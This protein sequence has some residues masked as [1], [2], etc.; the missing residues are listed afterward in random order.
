MVGGLYVLGDD[1]PSDWVKEPW[2]RRLEPVSVTLLMRVRV[3]PGSTSQRVLIAF[4]SAALDFRHDAGCAFRT[5]A[6]KRAKGRVLN[7]IRAASRKKQ[8]AD[9]VRLEANRFRES[10]AQQGAFMAMTNSGTVVVPNRVIHDPHDFRGDPLRQV[11][12]ADGEA[13][14][15][16]KLTPRE[17]AAL[18]VLLSGQRQTNADKKALQRARKKL[19]RDRHLS[20]TDGG[21][22]RD[23]DQEG[24]REKL[25]A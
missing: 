8:H 4:H 1:A 23:R 19:A 17:Q 10:D 5:H 15:R 16:D 14:L 3:G 18:D 9:A 25:A 6:L 13:E 11:L 22:T 24:T 7:D 21:F 12:D 2:P 20:T